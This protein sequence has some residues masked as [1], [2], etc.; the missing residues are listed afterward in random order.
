MQTTAQSAHDEAGKLN[1]SI[2]NYLKSTENAAPVSDDLLRQLKH[3]CGDLVSV[4]DYAAAEMRDRFRPGYDGP[5]YFPIANLGQS[6]PEFQK[7][8]DGQ[9]PGLRERAPRLNEAILSLQWFRNREYPWLPYLRDFNNVSKHEGPPR[10]LLARVSLTAT[11]VGDEGN[12][13]HAEGTIFMLE[14]IGFASKFLQ[15]SSEGILRF[16]RVFAEI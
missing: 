5:I 15:A 8:V 3:I 11:P 2:P 7:V 4:L 13:Q 16:A 12:S 9:F 10:H 1:A 14:S 6:E